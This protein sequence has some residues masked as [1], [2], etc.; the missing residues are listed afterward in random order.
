MTGDTLLKLGLRQGEAV[1]LR[2]TGGTLFAP[3]VSGP[4]RLSALAPAG[5]YY[6]FT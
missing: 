4:I 5:R 6:F 1:E 2:F 3:Q